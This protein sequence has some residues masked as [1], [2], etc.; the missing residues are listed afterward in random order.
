MFF[1]GAQILGLLVYVAYSARAAEQARAS[2]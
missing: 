2:G 1:V